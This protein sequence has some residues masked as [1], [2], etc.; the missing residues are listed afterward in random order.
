[1]VGCMTLSMMKLDGLIQRLEELV[2]DHK[3]TRINPG[4]CFY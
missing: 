2:L 1:L 3:K 4:F